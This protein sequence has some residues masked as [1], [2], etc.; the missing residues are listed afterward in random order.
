MENE[1]KNVD[2][3]LLRKIDTSFKEMTLELIEYLKK[4][5]RDAD[6]IKETRECYKLLIWHQ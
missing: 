2:L 4:G 6:L 3:D 1:S 5:C